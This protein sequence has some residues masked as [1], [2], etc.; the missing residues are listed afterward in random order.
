MSY[1]TI[2]DMGKLIPLEMLIQLTDDENTGALVATRVEE[3]V[4]QADSEI[5]SYCAMKYGVPLDP[6]PEIVRKCSVDIA[7]YNLYSR[8]VEEIPP[9][10]SERY[11]NAVRCL[12]GIV[13]GTV[14]LGE[15]PAGEPTASG[16]E[17]SAN[18]KTAK[19]RVATRLGMAGF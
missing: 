16:D 14:S 17:A 8:R 13:R 5:D 19:D 10:R 9:T 11:R 18:T 1:S 7:I 15:S 4:R 12:E 6:V 3:A 2:D